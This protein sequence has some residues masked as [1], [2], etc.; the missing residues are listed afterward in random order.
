MKNVKKVI[1]KAFLYL[2]IV[3]TG[4]LLF[5]FML[6]SRGEDVL[7]IGISLFFT[8]DVFG[9]V[10]MILSDVLN[11]NRNNLATTKSAGVQYNLSK[12]QVKLIGFT[13][14]FAVALYALII[15]FFK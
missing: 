7:F 6:A 8:M 4:A 12:A 1:S 5:K 13:S 14:I 10:L 11:V 3:L 15:V 2:V 9:G